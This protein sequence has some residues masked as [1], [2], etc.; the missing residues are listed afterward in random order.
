MNFRD[1]PYWEK[2]HQASQKLRKET[3]HSFL[4]IAIAIC[5]FWITIDFLFW[6]PLYIW[7][8]SMPLAF[9]VPAYFLNKK[10][11]TSLGWHVVLISATLFISTSPLFF[12]PL[13][14]L[15]L[16]LFV[17]YQM[18]SLGFQSPQVKYFYI[19]LLGISV[20]GFLIL[21][22]VFPSETNEA[23]LLTAN[24]LTAMVAIVFVTASNRIQNQELKKSKELSVKNELKTIRSEERYRTLFESSPAGIL[25]LDLTGKGAIDCN[26]KMLAL[27]EAEKE[28]ILTGSSL[29]FSPSHQ[30]DGEL[31]SDKF[32]RLKKE[33]FRTQ[34]PVNTYWKYLTKNN[35]PF[36]A[37]VTLTPIQLDGETL[38]IQQI[39]DITEK[40]KAERELTK[41]EVNYRTLFDNGYDGIIIF[42]LKNRKPHSCNQVTLDMLGITKDEF[43]DFEFLKFAP[44]TQPNGQ[45]TKSFIW[46]YIK[47]V[48]KEKKIRF[49]W[50]QYNK[51]GKAFYAE[52]SAFA[53]PKPEEDFA[54]IIFKNTTERVITQRA[55][56]TVSRPII[57]G[58]EQ[59]FFDQ[60]TFEIA[61]F[62]QVSIVL[63]GKLQKDKKVMDA[64]G[65]WFKDKN[66]NGLSYVLEDTPCDQVVLTK[67]M[68]CYPSK[69]KKLFPKDK[70][71]E[72]WDVES[73]IA[74]PLFNAEKEMIGHFAILDN[75]PL[76]NEEVIH[77][78][79]KIFAT[80]LASE[81]EREE[82]QLELQRSNDELKKVNSEL[83][84]FVYSAAHDIRAPISSVLGL[85]N[86]SE[87][88]EDLAVIKHYLTLQKSSLKKLD[89]FITDLINYSINKR[90]DIADELIDL[91]ELIDEVIDQY[92]YLVN[93][94]HIDIQR[95]IEANAPLY[96]DRNRLKLILNNVISNAINYADL[97]KEAHVLTISIQVHPEKA[98]FHIWDN[99]QGIAEDQIPKI[100]DMFHRANKHSKGSGIG[101]YIT[102]EAVEKLG[103]V[104]KAES[105]H[106]EWT[107]FSFD[108]INQIKPIEELEVLS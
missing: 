4:L 43:E 60:L 68:K 63:V 12:D 23:E 44:R 7:F 28:D 27:F 90:R 91:Q 32:T 77:I 29:R 30:P 24:L 2:E 76:V 95:Q 59:H 61:Q 96:S 84:R 72:D 17:I 45:D 6:D 21:C 56:E 26:R 35:R 73:Y 106:K 36:D 107:L 85:I 62:L 33:Y 14:A 83:D 94:Q 40:K 31:S 80:A 10:G 34:K 9:L 97:N 52:V 99:G 70:D 8:A 49:E 74:Y 54:F 93:F 50:L 53:L 69:I 104:M 13:V 19:A 46:H 11:Y 1:T 78:T 87:E 15:L 42:D 100:F 102:Q 58:K 47:K 3:L 101:L 5:F 103:G 79:M 89:L 71:L 64:K 39:Q 22:Y 98:S 67:E 75:K 57:R 86:I 82:H 92:R 55:L 16:I 38:A 65:L 108:I 51:H 25:I 88:Q 81:M 20:S 37:E 18:V 48:K 41:I 105:S 66:I